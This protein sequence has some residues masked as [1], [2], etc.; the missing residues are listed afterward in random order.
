M[1]IPTVDVEEGTKI[2]A[3][4]LAVIERDAE[5]SEGMLREEWL[6]EMVDSG[7]RRFERALAPTATAINGIEASIV[8]PER[9]ISESTRAVLEALTQIQLA[10]PGVDTIEEAFVPVQVLTLPD[11]PQQL[12]KVTLVYSV[13]ATAKSEAEEGHSFH[14]RM[15]FQQVR[16]KYPAQNWIIEVSATC[17]ST[18]WWKTNANGQSC[19]SCAWI[20]STSDQ[21]TRAQMASSFVTVM[22][23]I[24]LVGS[25]SQSRSKN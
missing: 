5:A 17:S 25:S 23:Q 21:S 3:A 12:E 19:R 16:W 4:P 9:Q 11:P 14:T 10:P 7:L 1:T 13:R 20:G 6:E 18:S 22:L 2:D 8:A 15:L 24:S